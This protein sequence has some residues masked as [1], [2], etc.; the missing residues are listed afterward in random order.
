[1][2]DSNAPQ[3]HSHLPVIHAGLY[4]TG[5]GSM[6]QA[7]RMLGLRAHHGHDMIDNAAEWVL[8]EEAAEATWPDVPGAR[9][10]P[11]WTRADWDR[12]TG[13]YDVITDI[14]CL[15][16]EELIRVY[17]EARVVVIERDV[18]K[19]L[20]SF[21]AGVMTVV[22]GWL[23]TVMMHTV[24]PLSGTRILYAFRKTLLGGFG[25]RGAAELRAR[26][27]QLYA[28]YYRR[29]RALV[30]PERRLEYRIGDGW[31]PLCAFLEKPVPNAPFPRVNEAADHQAKGK[32]YYARQAKQAFRKAR[33]LILAT[34]ALGIATFAA[35]R[36]RK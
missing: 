30:P 2:A 9:P 24:Y 23:S 18:D 27:P 36:L 29:I 14:G 4:R 12:I 17:P 20:P 8:W 3:P 19:W 11:R 22:F 21:E 1:M 28:E 13:P 25:V 7:Y 35:R 5:T 6:A 26:A 10:R 34:V 15:F 33:P 16:V 32:A 31:E